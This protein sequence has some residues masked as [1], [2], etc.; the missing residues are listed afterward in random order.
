MRAQDAVD[1][2]GKI[3]RLKVGEL[4]LLLAESISKRL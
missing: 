3:F 4:A 2:V 1:S